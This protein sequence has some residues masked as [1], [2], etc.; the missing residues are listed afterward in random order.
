MAALEELIRS[1]GRALV[2]AKQLTFYGMAPAAGSELVRA[3]EI[4]LQIWQQCEMGTQL[5]AALLELISAQ[6]LTQLAADEIGLELQGYELELDQL[7]QILGD[8]PGEIPSWIDPHQL[9]RLA[10]LES[11]QAGPGG[12]ESEK[13]QDGPDQQRS[14]QPGPAGARRRAN[15]DRSTP[16]QRA[17]ADPAMENGP[18]ERKMQADLQAPTQLELWS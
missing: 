1:Y 8:H 12:P 4:L 10:I 15:G 5:A 16:P 9:A 6:D 13:R 18:A 2:R 3:E 14:A 7:Q 17:A 11:A